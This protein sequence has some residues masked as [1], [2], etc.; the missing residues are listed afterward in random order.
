M[1]D[2]DY[3]IFLENLDVEDLAE[4]RNVLTCRGREGTHL[5]DVIEKCTIYEKIE[6][7]PR[8]ASYLLIDKANAY[9]VWINRNTSSEKIFLELLDKRLDN[10]IYPHSDPESYWATR[11]EIEKDN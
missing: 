5:E 9:K 1:A 6:V 8:R 7:I 3:L 4:L 11:A 10:L 2:N